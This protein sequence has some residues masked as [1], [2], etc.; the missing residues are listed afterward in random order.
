MNFQFTPHPYY[1]YHIFLQLLNSTHFFFTSQGHLFSTSDNDLLFCKQHL[2][3]Q[4]LSFIPKKFYITPLLNFVSK[5]KPRL[6]TLV[7]MD[8]GT[9]AKKGY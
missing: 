2:T 1:F 6:W 5:T 7:G 8:H 3:I 9:E 4:M